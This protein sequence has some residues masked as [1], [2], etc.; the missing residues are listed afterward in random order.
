MVSFFAFGNMQT[1][2]ETQIKVSMGLWSACFPAQTGWSNFISS[3][4]LFY[5]RETGNGICTD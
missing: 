1:K 4:S 2:P 3:L 5:A